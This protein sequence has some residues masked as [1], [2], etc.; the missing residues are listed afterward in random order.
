MKSKPNPY[1]V[2]YMKPGTVKYTAVNITPT[3]LANK[4]CKVISFDDFKKGTVAM[5]FIHHW[6]L[7]QIQNAVFVKYEDG[8]V[9]MMDASA[10]C[11]KPNGRAGS[12]D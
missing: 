6:Q 4:K 9:D 10:L 12:N 1:T 7:S 8:T 3:K 11:N 5:D 2:I